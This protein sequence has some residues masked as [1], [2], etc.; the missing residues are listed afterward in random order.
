MLP[1]I[2]S[3]AWKTTNERYTPMRPLVM[4]FRTDFRAAD[5]GD[6]FMYGPAFL[7]NPVTEPAA[8]TRHLYLPKATWFDFWTGASQVGG[9]AIDAPA[10]IETMPLFIR[11]GSILP[12]GPDLEWA[13]QKPADPLELRIYRGADGSFTLYEDE[14]DTYN[15]E[16]GLLATI[17]LAWDDAKQTLVIGDRKG[18]F[19]GMLKER[20]FNVVFVG[21]SHGVG[22]DAE[23]KPDRVVRYSGKA[24]TVTP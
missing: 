1:Y 3:L 7:V 14:G 2:Y 17:P 23:S 13:S 10:P 15:Y 6:Q 12:L 18:E 20:T 11:A 24:M 22:I 16:K 4:D 19:P 9:K 5:I 8:T 21:P